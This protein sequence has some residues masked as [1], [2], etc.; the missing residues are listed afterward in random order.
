LYTVWLALIR[1]CQIISMA[2]GTNDQQT[3]VSIAMGAVL[4]EQYIS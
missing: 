1:T 3:N 2:P 4:I